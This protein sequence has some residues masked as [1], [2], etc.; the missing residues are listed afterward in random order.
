M[1]FTPFHF[2]PALLAG[3]IL[4]P[5]FDLAAMLIC[6]VILDI[7][8]I[9]VL[10]LNLEGHLHGISHTYFVAAMVSILVSGVLWLLREPI[11]SIVSIF[12]VIQEP[13]KSRILVAS[14]FGTYSHVFMDSFIYWEM[15]PFYPILGNPFLGLIATGV[16]YQFCLYCGIIGVLLYS[17]RF[18][19][20]KKEPDTDIVDPFN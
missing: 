18:C 17:V 15:N 14:L 10:F 8:P 19:I 2:G 20:M 12:G 9:L 5:F 11:A 7:E 3:V 1:P 4:F 16:I 13:K 6:C